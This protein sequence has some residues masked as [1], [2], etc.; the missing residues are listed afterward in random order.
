MQ[1]GYTLNHLIPTLAIIEN[2]NPPAYEPVALNEDAAD[3][4]GEPASSSSGKPVTS[5]LRATRRVLQGVAGWKSY[6]RGIVCAFV[7]SFVSST[8]DGLVSSKFLPVP[9][10]ALIASLAL[11][12]LSAAWTHI[13]ISQPSKLPFYRRLPPFKKTFEATCFPILAVWLAAAV[14]GVVPAVV[15]Q[16]LGLSSAR[17]PGAVFGEDPPQFDAH[18]TW[19]LLI[20]ILLA[21]VLALGGIVPATVLLVR[22]QASLLPPDEDT[23]VPFDRSFGGRVDPAVVGGKGYVTIRDALATFDRASWV[24]I[25]KL[26]AKILAVTLVTYFGIGSVIA[27]Q[28]VLLRKPKQEEPL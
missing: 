11:A 16:A 26:Y 4:A 10:G 28:F 18:D 24:R 12:Q 6:F 3:N 15:A 2:P 17:D 7:L 22:T 5:S 1:V 25:Y 14:T 23:I 27:A 21:V 20:V 19:K 13:V 8:L 9:L